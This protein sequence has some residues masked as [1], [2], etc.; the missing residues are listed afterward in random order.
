MQWTNKVKYQGQVKTAGIGKQM[1]WKTGF[2]D[3]DYDEIR[4][5]WMVKLTFNVNPNRVFHQL[6]IGHSDSLAVK[7]GRLMIENKKGDGIHIK[8][9][10]DDI[11]HARQLIAKIQRPAIKAAGQHNRAQVGITSTPSSK[12]SENINPHLNGSLSSD[13]SP[14]L[15][16]NDVS[17]IELENWLP[18]KTPSSGA[19]KHP[20]P[21]SQRQTEATRS[22]TNPTPSKPPPSTLSVSSKRRLEYSGA[23]NN[24]GSKQ[25]NMKNV[26]DDADDLLDEIDL[27]PKRFTA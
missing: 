23:Q 9:S 24:S 13:S 21:V 17:P 16:S 18:K 4:D 27:T 25:N 10:S 22:N 6:Q 11:D 1:S 8:L 7:C 15:S 14:Q 2:V 26:Y 3:F 5:K 20:T 19:Q 12:I